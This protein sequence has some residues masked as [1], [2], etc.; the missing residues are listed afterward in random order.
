MVN[1]ESPFI[2]KGSNI[3]S[4]FRGGGRK[5]LCAGVIFK[6]KACGSIKDNSKTDVVMDIIM[7]KL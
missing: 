5:I 6:N 7:G 3:C 2:C 1:I 4:F